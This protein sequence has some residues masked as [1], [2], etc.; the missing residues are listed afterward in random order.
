MASTRRGEEAGK[1]AVAGPQ[2]VVPA[3]QRDS[4]GRALG[5]TLGKRLR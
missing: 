5:G 1:V 3:H 4:C 2:G